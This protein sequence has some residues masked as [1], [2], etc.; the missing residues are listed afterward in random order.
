MYCFNPGED[1]QCDIYDNH[2]RVESLCLGNQ[3]SSIVCDTQHVETRS[4][5]SD[6]PL[7]KNLDV[8]TEQDTWAMH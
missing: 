4:Q 2:I 6:Y 3:I 7:Y 8:V 5:K 1:R